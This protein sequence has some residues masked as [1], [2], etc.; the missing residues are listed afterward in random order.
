MNPTVYNSGWFYSL[1]YELTGKDFTIEYLK[2]EKFYDIFLLII[3]DE[4]QYFR[5]AM[6]LSS[7]EY[8]LKKAVDNELTSTM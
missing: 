3:H 6:R 4:P 5:Q 7:A 8:V 2:A 1:W